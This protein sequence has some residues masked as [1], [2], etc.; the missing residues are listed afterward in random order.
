MKTSYIVGAAVGLAALYFL[1]KSK[2]T[3]VNVPGAVGRTLTIPSS[4]TVAVD[5]AASGSLF[6]GIASLFKGQPQ[7]VSPSVVTTQQLDTTYIPPSGDL[8]DP[9]TDPSTDNVIN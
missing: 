1:Y 3:T 4:N 2:Q 7:S 5:L 6:S 9:L 8:V